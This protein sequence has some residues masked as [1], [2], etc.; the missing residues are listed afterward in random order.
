MRRVGMLALLLPLLVFRGPPSM[1]AEQGAAAA[2]PAKSGPQVVETAEIPLQADADERFAQDVVQRSRGQDPTAKLRPRLESLGTAVQQESQRFKRDELKLLS[3]SRLE[4]LE[5]HWKF[6]GKQLDAWRRDLQQSMD[7]YTEDA[8]ELARRRS[9]WEATRADNAT[10]GLASALD[11][12]IQSVLGQIAL[13]EQAV[14]G[15]IDKQVRLMRHANAVETAIV[16]GQRAVATAIAYNDS[17]LS[18]IDS[19]PIWELWNDPRAS[20]SAL[21]SVALGIEVE[22]RFLDEYNAANAD[23]LRALNVVGLLLLPLLLWLSFRT[24]RVVSDDPEIQAA[25]RVLRRPI[26]SWIVLAMVGI[27]LL[28]PDAPVLR[29]QAAFLLAVIPVL[30]LLPPYVYAVLGPWPYVATGLYLLQRLSLLLVANPYYYRLYLLGLTLLTAALLGWILWR[31]RPRAGAAE[32]TFGRKLVRFAGWA[33]IGALLL[34]AVANVVGNVSLAEMLTVAILESGY[35]G[36]V[37]YAGVTVLSSVLRLLLA[38]RVFARFSVVTQHAGPLLQSFTRLLRLAALVAWVVV[39]LNEFRIFRPISAVVTSVLT[40][41]LRFGQISISLGGVLLFLFSVWLAFWAAK[42]VRVILQDEVLPKMSLPRGVGNSISSLTYYAMVMLGLFFALAAAGFEVSQLAIVVGALERRHR[43]RPAERGQQLRLGPDPD[44]R[45]PDPAR[46]RGR[47]QRHLR[48]GARDRHARHHAQHL[49]GRR[50]RGAERHAAEREADQLDPERH[51][52]P[53][54][55]QRRRRLRQRPEEGARAADGGDR[56]R[57]RHRD[58]TRADRAVLRLRRQLA[59]VRHPR[60]DQQLRR[61]GEDPQRPERARVRRAA[62]RRHRDSV[63]AARP[64]PAHGVAGGRRRARGP[65][66][67]D[68]ATPRRLML[69]EPELLGSGTR[70]ATFAL[71]GV[72]L[73]LAAVSAPWR[74]WLEDRERQWVWLVSLAVLVG[75]WSMNAGITPGLSLRFLLVTALTLMHGWQLAVIGGALA[76]A[77]AERG[78]SGRL[79]QLRR[80]PAVRDGRARGGHGAAAPTGARTPAAQLFHLLLRHR[81]RG[82]GARLQPGGPRARG[83]ARGQR[84]ARPRPRSAPSTSPCCR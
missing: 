84:H 70:I 51:G 60:L 33:G 29:H 14:S 32:P 82:L 7:R 15:P 40:H 83:A 2:T 61:L 16:E 58:R 19:P 66:A 42:T 25:N 55:R 23:F 20:E 4:S 53:H 54:R 76:L 47:G 10:T 11:G 57:A 38:R 3:I 62:G 37:L 48:Q 52:S 1:A 30:R 72:A 59:R 28:E 68:R 36:L 17:R 41:E 5:R 74:V 80:G 45:A 26:S 6:Y 78:R 9:N 31:R 46:R 44:V 69:V 24:R 27:V 8:A 39:V 67:A 49:R 35:V 64:A 81:V 43:L 71:S 50:R 12:R 79:G 34:S 77:G 65:R 22:K 13:A 56:R 73:A 63:P 21:K 75:L 18:R